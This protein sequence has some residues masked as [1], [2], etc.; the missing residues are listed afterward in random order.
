MSLRAELL[1]LGLRATFKLRDDV[2]PDIAAI[3]ARL[4]KFKLLAP[5]PPKAAKP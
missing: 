2:A 3:R 5:P 4:E 1:R